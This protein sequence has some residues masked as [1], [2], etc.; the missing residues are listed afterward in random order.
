MSSSTSMPDSLVPAVD[1][2]G[3]AVPIAAFD[4]YDLIGY[5]ASVGAATDE[6]HADVRTLLQGF[7]PVD[8]DQGLH[9]PRYELV[10]TGRVWQLR[11]NSTLVQEDVDLVSSLGALEW[12]V[13][14]AALAFRSD[15]LQLHGAALCAPTERA[16]ILLIGDSGSGKTTLALGLM[17][18]G[19]TPYGDDVVA[20]DRET[21]EV[22]PVRRAFH[23]SDQTRRVAAASTGGALAWA[24]GLPGFFS[25]PQ[26]AERPAPIRWVL[27]VAYAEHE[28]TRLQ[29]LSSAEAA[30]AMLG[31]TINLAGS[32]RPALSAAVRLVESAR[33]FRLVSGGLDDAL[34]VIQHLVAEPVSTAD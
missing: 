14:N 26:W 10:P 29:P 9:L 17:L 15:L 28:A 16:A 5:Q 11:I 31:Q 1:R 13:M 8:V 21:L 23:V 22:R 7:G 24:N 18:R 34:A 20:V 6:A 2:S 3:G 33:I 25:P 12:H 4:A 30:T 32:A 19:F 27:F